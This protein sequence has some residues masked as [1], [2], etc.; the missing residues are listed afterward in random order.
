[1]VLHNMGNHKQFL[2]FLLFDMCLK[3]QNLRFLLFGHSQLTDFTALSLYVQYLIYAS[4]IFL[5]LSDEIFYK[6]KVKEF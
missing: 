2:A 4:I 6:P 3:G 5:Q 1:M